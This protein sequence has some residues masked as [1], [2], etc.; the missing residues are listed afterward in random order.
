M[1]NPTYL[2]AFM[3]SYFFLFPC[4]TFFFFLK[5]HKS[6]L[7]CMVVFCLCHVVQSCHSQSLAVTVPNCLHCFSCILRIAHI[8]SMWGIF[9]STLIFFNGSLQ[10]PVPNESPHCRACKCSLSNLYWF[11]HISIFVQMQL[12]IF[13]VFSHSLLTSPVAYSTL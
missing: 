13:N 10:Y 1:L 6:S 3:F 11:Y 8:C 4:P 9:S 5:L 7:T 12:V 2:C